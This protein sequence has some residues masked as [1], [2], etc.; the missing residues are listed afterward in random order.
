MRQRTPSSGVYRRFEEKI[1]KKENV[2]LTSAQQQAFLNYVS[3]STSYHYWASIFVT[4]LGTGMRPAECLGLTRKDVDLDNKI[5]SVNHALLYRTVD[6]NKRFLI[7]APKTKSS[8]RCIPMSQDVLTVL[9]ETLAKLDKLHDVP[10]PIIDGY[11]DFIFRDYNGGLLTAHKLNC[12]ITRITH[13]YNTEAPDLA[14]E[15]Q[16][17]AL[18]IPNFS[19]YSLRQTF[20]ARMLEAGFDHKVIRAF[21]GSEG[22]CMLDFYLHPISE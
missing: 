3:Q 13:D 4:L 7:T 14:E 6:G 10:S 22:N 20:C 17:A 21:M 11:T 8:I 5:I 16:R 15:E 2:V 1:G 19:A 18:Q 12:V 9:T